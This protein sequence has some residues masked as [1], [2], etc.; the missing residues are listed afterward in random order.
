MPNWCSTSYR[1]EGN[2]E[3]LKK[4]YDAITHHDVQED[5]SENWEG[6]V[7]ISLGITWQDRTSDVEGGKYLRGFIQEEP[8]LGEDVLEFYAEEAWGVSDFGEILEENFPD[9]K[10]YFCGEEPNMEYFVTNDSTGK[11]FHC[12]AIVDCCINNEYYYE[13]FN[14]I[15]AAYQWIYDKTSCKTIEDIENFGTDP[16]DTSDNFINIYEYKIVK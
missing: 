8:S 7:L 5:S 14:S 6:N 11:Y 1:I 2:P 15:E 12:R 4:I 9:I 10:V 3:T 16:D 13:E